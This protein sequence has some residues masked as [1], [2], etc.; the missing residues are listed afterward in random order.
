MVVEEETF[1]N[2]TGEEVS[3]SN[4]LTEMINFYALKRSAGDTRVTD[5]NEGSEIRNFLE[6]ISVLGY[7]ILEDK[8]ELALIAFPDTA[9][10]EWL[11]KHGANP[12][13]RLER[14]IGTEATGFVTFSIP[15]A[16]SED[17][18]IPEGTIV[19]SS[20]NGLDYSTDSEIVLAVGDTD[21]TVSVTC[22]VEG[23]DGNCGIGTVNMINDDYLNVSGLSVN[24]TEAFTGGVDYEE[25]EE[26]RER[27]LNYVRRDDFGSLPYYESLADDIPGVHDVHFVDVE[28][29]SKKILVNG[30]IK[31]TPTTVLADVLEVYSQVGNHVLNH[32]FTVDR[33]VSVPL[34]VT[35]NLTV[36]ELLDEN[37]LN[38]LISDFFNG[39]SHVTGLTYD[40]LSIGEGLIVNSLVNAFEIFD[41]V[42]SV[43][44][45]DSDTSTALADISI[46]E[47]ELLTLGTVEIN[48]TIGE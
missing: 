19:V 47:N 16:V 8:N 28:G 30:N 45:I 20:E 36:T 17:I 44:L 33:P 32:H 15:E 5:F 31:P 21:A 38:Y 29:F 34:N 27:L 7:Y 10:G 23:E 25:D 18:I 48:Q 39:G 42:S 41:G 3:R 14:D 2:I 24:N 4:I 22:L 46:D 12:F 13:I 11:D 9:T 26:Y 1:Y 40:G 6:V 35:V 37:E 43:E